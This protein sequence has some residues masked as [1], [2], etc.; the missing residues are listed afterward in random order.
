MN[1]GK[2]NEI[3]V[4]GVSDFDFDNDFDSDL[5]LITYLIV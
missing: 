5:D 3:L 2:V 1:S 4:C